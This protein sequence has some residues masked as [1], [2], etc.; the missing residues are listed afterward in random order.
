MPQIIPKRY[1][2]LYCKCLFLGF[3]VKVG[4]GRAAPDLE[5]FTSS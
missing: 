5:I 3:A 1:I 2:I 4:G